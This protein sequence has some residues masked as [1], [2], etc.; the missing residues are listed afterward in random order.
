MPRRVDQDR[1]LVWQ[2]QVAEYSEDNIS[3]AAYHNAP[4]NETDNI[5]STH[6]QAIYNGSSSENENDESEELPDAHVDDEAASS[7]AYY[8]AQDVD[9]THAEQQTG[10]HRPPESLHDLGDEGLDRLFDIVCTEL[11]SRVFMTNDS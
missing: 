5:E 3:P 4:E 11:C 8:L 1:L 9:M 2:V 6:A 7:N 10:D